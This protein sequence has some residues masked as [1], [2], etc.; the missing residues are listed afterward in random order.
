MRAATRSASYAHS[1]HGGTPAD[2]SARHTSSTASRGTSRSTPSRPR[3]AHPP[4]GSGL[5]AYR[6]VGR[7]GTAP[8]GNLGAGTGSTSGGSSGSH[9][10]AASASPT[11]GPS[12]D[13]TA[14]SPVA[15]LGS[16]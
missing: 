15:S 16:T 6:A 2:P 4:E 7:G 11:R 10:S 14:S 1:P 5:V 8:D 3:R 12:R 9:P 13:S